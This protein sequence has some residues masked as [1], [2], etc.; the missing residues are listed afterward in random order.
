MNKEQERYLFCNQCG[1]SKCGSNYEHECPEWDF[2]T[3]NADDVEF[4]ACM[5]YISDKQDVIS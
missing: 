3:I 1:S 5:C 4:E 2:A